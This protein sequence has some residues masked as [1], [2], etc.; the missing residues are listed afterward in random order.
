M[1]QKK[2]CSEF[3]EWLERLPRTELT[4]DFKTHLEN[5]D[6]C[7]TRYRMLD[8][9]AD[10][11]RALQDVHVLDSNVLNRIEKIVQ[12]EYIQKRNRKV[13]FRLSVLGIA[14]LPFVIAVN[15]LWALLGFYFLENTLS[16]TLAF[17]Y[18]VGFTLF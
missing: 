7:R 9:V 11:L 4:D 15:L 6:A 12:E 14:S 2:R 18:L 1:I 3:D 8:D 16:E 13:T 5:C 10:K 17:V